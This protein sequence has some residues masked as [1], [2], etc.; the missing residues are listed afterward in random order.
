MTVWVEIVIFTDNTTSMWIKKRGVCVKSS[1]RTRL[2]F[3]FY[4]SGSRNA[5]TLK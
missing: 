1:Y 3:V 4:G 5:A 2:T